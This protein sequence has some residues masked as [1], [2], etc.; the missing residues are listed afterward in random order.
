VTY[1]R[2]NDTSCKDTK[3]LPDILLRFIFPTVFVEPQLSQFYRT[4]NNDCLVNIGIV[5]KPSI[6]AF[7]IDNLF[8]MD[9][10]LMASQP[11]QINFESELLGF[12]NGIKIENGDPDQ[13][14]IDDPT[15]GGSGLTKD[16]ILIIAICGAGVVIL[17]LAIALCVVCR[18]RK[19]LLR[20]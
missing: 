7:D 14:I 16:Q 12:K 15:D 2:F 6:D 20:Q 18:K 8:I 1:F 11:Y 4:D 19:A 5:Y 17:A 13:P 10:Y 3:N 9:N